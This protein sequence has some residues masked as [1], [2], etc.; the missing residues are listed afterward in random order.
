MKCAHCG[1]KCNGDRRDMAGEFV[2]TGCAANLMEI[3][4]RPGD[5][6]E[7]LAAAHWN[8]IEQVIRNE[9]AGMDATSEFNL[10]EYCRQVGFHYRTAFVHGYKH[11]REDK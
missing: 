3:E 4:N 11:G 8:Y 5:N 6:A 2:C 1:R 7:E 10:D 9:Y